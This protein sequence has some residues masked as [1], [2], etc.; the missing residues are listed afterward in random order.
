MDSDEDAMSG[1]EGE[2]ELEAPVDYEQLG[3]RGRRSHPS[4]R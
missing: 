1:E 3:A 2:L 4:C